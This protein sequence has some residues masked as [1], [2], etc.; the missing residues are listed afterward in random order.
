[1]LTIRKLLAKKLC[2]NFFEWFLGSE[3]DVLVSVRSYS[4]DAPRC[5]WI[6]ALNFCCQV[7]YWSLPKK[8][9]EW[10]KNAYSLHHETCKLSKKARFH[11][12]LNTPR[13]SGFTLSNLSPSE[14]RNYEKKSNLTFQLA[15]FDLSTLLLLLI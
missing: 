12:P 7:K 4:S 2:L 9:C 8:T 5:W 11:K 6:R 3:C 13:K 10:L 1:M 14:P 15:T